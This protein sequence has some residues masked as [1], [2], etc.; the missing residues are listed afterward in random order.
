M[1]WRARTNVACQQIVVFL[2]NPDGRSRAPSALD[3]R[4][5]VQS[6]ASVA[7]FWPGVCP[8]PGQE[9]PARCADLL[10]PSCSFPLSCQSLSLMV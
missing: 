6:A 5:F 2:G 8:A 10:I 9:A 3:L 7:G 1:H 4:W